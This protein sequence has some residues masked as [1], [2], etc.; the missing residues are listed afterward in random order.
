MFPRVLGIDVKY[1]TNNER[2]PLL[3]VV[4]RTGSNKIFTVMNCYMPSEQQYAFA[5]V[6]GTALQHCLDESALARTE[7]IPTDEDKDQ[8]AALDAIISLGKFGSRVS[9]RFCKWHLVRFC[10]IMFCLYIHHTNHTLLLILSNYF[11]QFVFIILRNYSH[12]G[13]SQLSA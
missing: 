2:R 12:E 3:R 1:G 9:K 13:E 10:V 5:W 8:I 11:A 4:G 7:I 6:F